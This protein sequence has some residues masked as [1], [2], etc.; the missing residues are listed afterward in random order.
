MRYLLFDWDE[1]SDDIND[2]T[3]LT[4]Q[5]FEELASLPNGFVFE[6]SEDF[7]SAYNSQQ[8]STATHQ[9]RIID[10]ITPELEEIN[11]LITENEIGAWES[12]L[13]GT[14]TAVILEDF[15]E[16]HEECDGETTIIENQLNQNKTKKFV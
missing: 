4:D 11:R 9:L 15:Q 13:E 3:E 2:P 14:I 7:N 8:I 16:V 10:N 5:Q 1:V 6:N 12:D